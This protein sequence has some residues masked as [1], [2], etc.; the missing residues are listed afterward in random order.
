V[1]EKVEE[2]SKW[3]AAELNNAVSRISEKLGRWF[4]AA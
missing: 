4:G 1:L 2:R 3:T